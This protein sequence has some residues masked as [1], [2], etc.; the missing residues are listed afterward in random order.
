M[1][2]RGFEPKTEVE[3]VAQF[4]PGSGWVPSGKKCG[5]G[6][7]SMANALAFSKNCATAYIMKQVG[8]QQ[9][10]DFLNPN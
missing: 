9:F 1:E 2:E 3:N 7:I 8:P 6:S 10:S 4:F 5:G